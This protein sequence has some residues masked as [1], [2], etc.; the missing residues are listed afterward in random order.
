MGMLYF[1][2]LG[3][4]TKRQKPWQWCFLKLTVLDMLQVSEPR[5][6]KHIT[7][8]AYFELLVILWIFSPQTCPFLHLQVFLRPNVLGVPTWYWGWEAATRG[9]RNCGTAHAGSVRTSGLE[10]AKLQI[11]I[12][13]ECEGCSGLQTAASAKLSREFPSLPSPTFL[14]TCLLYSLL[15][16]QLWPLARAQLFS[17][18][19]PWGHLP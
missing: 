10:L 8:I 14:V 6:R 19:F 13:A 3:Q 9:V 2:F 15:G 11:Q 1:S 7:G 5:N 12:K 16:K 4:G 18:Q 17:C